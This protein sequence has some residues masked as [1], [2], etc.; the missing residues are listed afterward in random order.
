MVFVLCGCFL[1]DGWEQTCQDYLTIKGNF[2]Q[3]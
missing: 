3:L 2:P 1:E